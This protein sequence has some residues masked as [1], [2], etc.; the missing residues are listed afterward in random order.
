MATHTAGTKDSPMVRPLITRYARTDS[1][2]LEDLWL[3]LACNVEDSLLQ[4]G[5]TPGADYTIRDCYTLAQPLVVAMF[6]RTHDVTF[7]CEWPDHSRPDGPPYDTIT[8]EEIRKQHQDTQR[9][10]RRRQKP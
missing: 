10:T 7:A 1:K 2:T 9:A 8:L 4:A 5:A 6:T 3:V